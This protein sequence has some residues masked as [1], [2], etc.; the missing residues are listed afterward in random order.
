MLNYPANLKQT[1]PDVQTH[2]PYLSRDAP[3]SALNYYGDTHLSMVL[4]AKP[5]SAP[6]P[7]PHPSTF[8]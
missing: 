1:N 3:S 5:L 4:N 7:L 6:A 2:T 8:I